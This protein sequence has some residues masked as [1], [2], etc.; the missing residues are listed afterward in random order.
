M[1]QPPVKRAAERSRYLLV[2]LAVAACGGGSDA[3]TSS[4]TT[5]PRDTVVTT[6]PPAPSTVPN[7]VFILG[8]AQGWTST[9]VQM[10]PAVATSK[11]PYLRTPG[12]D[13]LAAEGMRYTNFYA[14][15]PRC[16]PSRAAFFTGHSPAQLHIT[17][18]KDGTDGVN[19]NSTIVTPISIT[20]LPTSIPTIGSLLRASGY[21]TAHFGK[22]HVGRTDPSAYGFDESDGPT[23]NGG[24]L[25]VVH[26]NPAESYGLTSR[27]VDFMKRQVKA[28][29]PF[30]VQ[31]SHYPGSVADDVLPA[32]YSAA[33]AQ[34]TGAPDNSVGVDATTL[35]M[36]NTIRQVQAALDSLGIA[37]STYVIFS[38]DHGQQGSAAN[39]PL[40]WGKGTV[41]E[42][43]VRV[44]L[45]ISGP[46]IPR[47]TTSRVQASGVDLVPTILDLVGRPL[48]ASVRDI[49][50]GSLKAVLTGGGTGAVVRPASDF[51][52]H[53]PHYDFDPIGPASTLLSGNFKLIRAYED[54]SLRL[55]DLSTD[56]GERNDLARTLPAKATEM[57]AKLTSYLTAVGA[58][59]PTRK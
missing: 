51:V 46:G 19:P 52:V 39:P 47:G 33:R 20:D 6:P 30:Y 55:F 28:R 54:N 58:Q 5:P 1:H 40:T 26:P 8:E 15:S 43:G 48:S 25:N 12:L 45:L 44:P 9:S 21:A 18:V 7:V 22:W 24:M 32:T 50:G 16:T 11:H 10:D 14:P 38:S 41:W 13:R 4:T 36:D 57:N 37:G 31:L 42:G 23:N 17:F 29:K 35:E 27:A 49:E 59:L 53:F 3:P 34:L 56:L 2:L